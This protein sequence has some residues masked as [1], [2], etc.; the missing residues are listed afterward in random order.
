MSQK[1]YGGFTGWGR[2]LGGGIRQRRKK[3]GIREPC[4]WKKSEKICGIFCFGKGGEV[5]IL[6]FVGVG[7]LIK[8]KKS[9]RNIN[10]RGRD[11]TSKVNYLYMKSKTKGEGRINMK[12]KPEFKGWWGVTMAAIALGYHIFVWAYKW[13]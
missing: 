8:T 5:N 1:R 7:S 6:A 3:S 9:A 12:S 4:C 13:G 11:R 10:I 2:T